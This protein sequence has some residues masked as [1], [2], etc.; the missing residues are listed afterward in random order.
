MRIH[1]VFYIL[2]LK[3]VNQN[4]TLAKTKIKDKIKYKI[5]QV[6]EKALIKE[7]DHYLIK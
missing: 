6:L 4:I 2:L 5:K 7:Q 1:L 3:K